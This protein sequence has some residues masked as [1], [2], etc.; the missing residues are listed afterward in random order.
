MTP[1]SATPVPDIDAGTYRLDPH[2]S[3]VTY[4]GRH[5]FGMGTVHAGFTIRS[6]E[7]SVT[8]SL[9]DVSVV[10]AIDATSFTSGS[11]KRDRD[12][13]SAGLLDVATYPDITY[14]SSA[15]RRDGDRVLVDGNVTSHGS[16]VSVQVT[17]TRVDTETDGIR[18][19]AGAQHLD[20]YAFGI[21]KSRGMVGRFLDL[22]FDVLAVSDR[23]ET[24]G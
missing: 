19:H 4:S 11:A 10:A 7:I 12:V 21:T 15:L 5:M 8:D 2:R 18:I 22:D 6:G 13:K 1:T 3:K 24:G 17:V 20:R 9:T 23:T 16:T 14:A